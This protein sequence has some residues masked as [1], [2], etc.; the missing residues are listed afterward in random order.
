[1]Y[2]M[3]VAGYLSGLICHGFRSLCHGHAAVFKRNVIV[4]L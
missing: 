2:K 3:V 4:F 1:M